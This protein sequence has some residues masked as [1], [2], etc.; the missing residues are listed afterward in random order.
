M[1]TAAVLTPGDVSTI[2]NYTKIIGTETPFQYTYDPPE[3]QEKS[4]L[5]TDPRSVTIRDI[6]GKE[7][8]VSLDTTGFQF[9]KHISREKE[10]TDEERIKNAYYKEVEE[11]LKQQTGAKRVFIFDHTVR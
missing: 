5:D 11:F 2:L 3:G 6:R 9:V 7:D 1:A 4:N 8:T 10:F